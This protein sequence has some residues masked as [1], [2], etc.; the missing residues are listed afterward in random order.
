MSRRY[1]SSTAVT[2]TLTASLTSGATSATVASTTGWPTSYPFTVLLDPDTASEEVVNVTNVAGLTIT[3]A[4]GQ[5][6]T[7]GV[8][9]NSGAAV[10]H[11]VSARDFDEPNAHVNTASGA[12][13][14]DATLWT[15]LGAWTSW[16]PTFAGFTLGNG[17]VVAKYTQVGKIVHWNVVVTCGSTSADSA[18]TATFTLPVTAARSSAGVGF[19]TGYKV[20]LVVQCGTTLADP[21]LVSSGYPSALGT[22]AALVLAGVVFNFSGTYEAA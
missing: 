3:I 8:A 16:T 9:H 15:G 5:D 21:S 13:S 20:P 19:V 14:L 1:Y 22:T 17:T 18:A 11:G 12:H 7:S 6:G 4:R 10:K 2:T